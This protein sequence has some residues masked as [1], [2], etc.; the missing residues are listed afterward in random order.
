MRMR[1][2]RAMVIR[3]IT[4]WA[5]NTKERVKKSVFGEAPSVVVAVQSKSP[6]LVLPRSHGK[7]LRWLLSEFWAE[8]IRVP[9]ILL[10]AYFINKNLEKNQNGGQNSPFLKR[11]QFRKPE[12]DTMCHQSVNGMTIDFIFKN[13]S[14]CHSVNFPPASARF[15]PPDARGKPFNS[16]S[17]C[18]AGNFIASL[19]TGR[20]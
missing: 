12:K 19:I 17:V 15:S 11:G 16:L 7:K 2:F 5:S 1:S 13:K 4:F 8:W 9:N 3:A 18:I 10:F 20:L 14:G 6:R